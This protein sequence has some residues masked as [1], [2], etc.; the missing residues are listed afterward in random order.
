METNESFLEI[1]AKARAEVAKVIIGQE[2]VIDHA[3]IAIFAGQHVLIEGVP[4]VAIKPTRVATH[5]HQVIEIIMNI[6][7]MKRIST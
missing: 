5:P 2:S 4:G 6:F 1:P 3:L 7:Y